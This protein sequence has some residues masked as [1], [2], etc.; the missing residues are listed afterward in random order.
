M[1]H[2]VVVIATL[3]ALPVPRAGA[4]EGA[5]PPWLRGELSVGA[6]FDYSSGDYGAD[7]DTDIWYAPFSVA[8]LFDHF[9]PTPFHHDQLELK[10]TVPFLR[11]EGP[12][13]VVGGIDGPVVVDGGGA[14]KSES[15]LGDVLV[16]ASYL[17]FPSEESWLPAAELGAKVKIP[18]ARESEGLGTGE[19]AYT[20]QLDLFKRFGRVTPV[21]GVG[22]RIAEDAR[23]YDLRNS[24]FASVGASV[25]VTDRLSTGVFYDWRQAT[26]ASASDAHEL[27]PF[28]SF[29]LREGVRVVPYGVFG[30]TDGSPDYGTGLQLRFSVGVR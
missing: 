13:D 12:G 1:L 7:D 5:V 30:F 6:G 23:D 8:Y 22:Y 27:F 17:L 14:R 2:V 25:R 15:G 4:D 29:A 18:T 21:A 26:S 28:F 10:V 20:V 9:W 19:P 11:L 3:L 24:L 16:K